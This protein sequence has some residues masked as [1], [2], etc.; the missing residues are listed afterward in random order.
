MI[1]RNVYLDRYKKYINLNLVK[2]IT[3][4][5]RSG[6]TYFMKQIIDFLI[7]DKKVSEENILYIDKEDLEFDFIKDYVS[8][9]NYITEKFQNIQGKKYLLIDE[10]QDILQWEKL[11]RSYV[12]DNDYDIY[13]TGSN[14]NLLSG[15]LATYLTGRYIQLHIYPLTFQEF[16]EFRGNNQ[17]T[18]KVEFENYLKYGGLPAIHKMD[19]DDEIIYSYIS[20]VFHSILFKDIVTRYNIRNSSLL[21]DVF[22]YLSD[23]IGNIVSSKK[24]SDYLKNEKISMSIDS[25]REYLMYFQNVFLLNK[26]QRYDIK[27]KKLLDLY[28]KYYLGDLGFRNYLLGYK[29][30]DISQLLENVIFLELKS[31]GY[32]VTIGKV[33]N[34]EVDFIAKKDGRIDYYQVTYM[35]LN[36]DTIKR[37][38]GVFENISDNYPKFVLSMDEI[39]D[40]NFNGIIRKNIID[41]LL[42]K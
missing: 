19:F 35:L 12:K 34:L 29:K 15:E 42:D 21:L 2:V 39:F 38:F 3:G 27:G 22:K 31:R 33:D 14:S 26:A 37:E 16:I 1:T 7:N 10:I 6:K 30:G 13:I 40:N 11:I 24:I 9:N 32:E 17:G 41:W 8:L 36:Q 20:G 23:N 25:L 5:R 28:E 18:I 4:I